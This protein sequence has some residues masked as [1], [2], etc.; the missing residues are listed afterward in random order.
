LKNYGVVTFQAEDEIS[1]M[2]SVVG[3]AF[4]GAL[5]VTGTSGPGIALKAEAMGLAVMLELPSIIVNV[6][7]GGPSTGL[8]TKTEQADLFQAI[9]GRNGEC[10][11]PVLAAATPA[12]CFWMA[13][14]AARIAL[15]FMT[16]VMLLSDGYLANGTEPW[17]VPDIASLPKIDVPY[18][19]HPEKFFPYSRNER[20]SRP[21]AIPGTPGLQHR[22]G[23][24]EKQHLTGNV[25]YDSNNHEVMVKLRQEK[26]QGIQ[27]DIPLLQVHGDTEGELLIVG[28]GSTYGAIATAVEKA[29]QAGKPVSSIHLKYLY[30]F[31][32]NLGDI[33]SKFNKILVP[34][35]NLGQLKHILQAQYLIPMNGLNKVK[36]RPFQVHEIVEAIDNAL[37]EKE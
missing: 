5:A 12:D 2:C 24:L 19:T 18:Y 7:R 6:Q 28:W 21:W 13:L 31:P 3:A 1:A 8:P 14:E 33:L 29:R 35:M 34:E 10:P 4:G 23:G 25:S 30:P 36:G 9:Y 26:V 15:Q 32:K 22:V 37:E 17:K 20:L 11:L 27:N 16:P